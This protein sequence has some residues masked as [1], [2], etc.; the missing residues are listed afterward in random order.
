MKNI[1]VFIIFC[2]ISL[3]IYSQSKLIPGDGYLLDSVISTHYGDSGLRTTKKIESYYNLTNQVKEINTYYNQ[4][5]YPFPDS[6]DWEL[7][8]RETIHYNDHYELESEIF[9]SKDNPTQTWDFT[10][11]NEYNSNELAKIKTYFDWLTYGDLW[12]PTYREIDSI[13]DTTIETSHLDQKWDEDNSQFE[14]LDWQLTTYNENGLIDAFITMIW[15]A[16]DFDTVSVDTYDY[17]YYPDTIII[18]ETMNGLTDIFKIYYSSES[19]IKHEVM[20]RK[21]CD[22]CSYRAIRKIFSFYYESGLLHSKSHYNWVNGDSIWLF[23]NKSEYEY[24]LSGQV[25]KYLHY[26]FDSLSPSNMIVYQFNDE[27]GLLETETSYPV[28]PNSNDYTVDHYYYTYTYVGIKHRTFQDCI[29]IIPN[30]FTTSTTIQYELN[31]PSE[32]TIK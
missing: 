14:N 30:P 2:T 24:N 16:G 9:E 26:D 27:T 5:M 32:V 8:E 12:L 23:F 29:T 6:I 4:N 15:I 25:T 19:T 20:Y 28:L 7:W 11:K 31:R 10:Y 1:V 18:Y 17:T 22:T 21:N 13:K 3:S